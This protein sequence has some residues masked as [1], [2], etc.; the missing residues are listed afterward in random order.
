MTT[1]CSIGLV[2]ANG[3]VVSIRVHRDGYPEHVAPILLT[4][5][6][7]FELAEQLVALGELSDL[8][9]RIDESGNDPDCCF[10]YHRDRSEL[11]H[12]YVQ[13]NTIDH[14]KF[15]CNNSVRHN[16]VFINDRWYYFDRSG[17]VEFLDEHYAHIQEESSV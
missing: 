11:L 10:A 12:Q 2:R 7:S 8:G 14:K 6:N 16:Y 13:P 3:Q 1:E 15:M 9:I 5:Y 4:H 17:T